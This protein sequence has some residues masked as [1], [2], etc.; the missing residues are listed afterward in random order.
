MVLLWFV[1]GGLL[2]DARADKLPDWVL[3]RPPNT[4]QYKFYL[5]RSNPISSEKQALREAIEDAQEQALIGR[6]GCLAALKGMSRFERGRDHGA[7]QKVL[8]NLFVLFYGLDMDHVA[9]TEAVSELC[10]QH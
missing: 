3:K 10:F 4:K 2:L 9:T 7:M 5:G 8:K 1:F 6:M